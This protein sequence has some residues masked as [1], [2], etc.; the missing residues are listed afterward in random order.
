MTRSCTHGFTV[1]VLKA[2]DIA[3][4]FNH[5][6]PAATEQQIFRL[7]Q[8]V[9]RGVKNGRITERAMAFTGVAEI[10]RPR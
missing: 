8:L 4:L 7:L 5:Y 10:I 9:T 1:P 3:K 2:A 6:L